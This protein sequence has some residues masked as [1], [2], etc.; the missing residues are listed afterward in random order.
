MKK[1]LRNAVGANA[2]NLAA[3]R[4]VVALKAEVELVV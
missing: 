2:S 1:E 4:N 3:E